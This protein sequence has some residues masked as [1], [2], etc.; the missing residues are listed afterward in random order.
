MRIITN[1]IMQFGFLLL[2]AFGQTAFAAEML[3]PFVLASNSSGGFNQTIEFVKNKLFDAGFTVS[4]EYS[5]YKDAHVIVVTDDKLK[6]LAKRSIG[7]LFAV[8]QRVSVTKVGSKIQV[9]YFN[10]VYMQYAYRLRYSL[11]FVDE[12]LSSALGRIK[13]FGSDNGLSKKKLIRYHYTYGMEYFDDFH[14][15]ATHSSFRKAVREVEK[16]FRK[17][18]GGVSKVAEIDIP[19][20]PMRFY[21]VKMTEG[22]SSDKKIMGVI[23]FERL[24]HTAHLPYELIIIDKRVF[25]FH[26]RFRIAI[27]FPDLSMMGPKSFMRI[28]QTPADLE[29][30]LTLVSGGEWIEISDDF[31]DF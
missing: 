24:K 9:A 15:L 5:P 16:G 10:P 29:K 27:S 2:L 1:K 28:T 12:K 13:T 17:N 22:Y 4:G 25:A 19:G 8:G 20:K 11:K 31:D 3:K 18:K 30:A 23:D 14:T 26:A 7:G 21:G 6:Q